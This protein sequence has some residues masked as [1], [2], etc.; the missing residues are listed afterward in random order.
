MKSAQWIAD[1]ALVTV[2]TMCL[3]GA[4]AAPETQ[5]SAAGKLGGAA[6]AVLEQGNIFN[7][8]DWDGGE[9]P[10]LYERSEQ[11]PLTAADVLRLSDNEFTDA[12]I[13]K[14]LQERR[15]ACDASVDGLLELKQ[16]GVSQAVVEAVSLHALPPNRSVDLV[17]SLDFEGLGG[18][19]AVSTEA[20][21]GYLYLIIPDGERERV[22]VGNLQAILARRWQRDTVVDNTDLLLPKK[23]RRVT[24]AAQVPLKTYGAKTAVV[25]ASTSPDIYTSADIPE[26]DRQHALEFAF[27]YP[28]SSLERRCSLQVLYRQDAMLPDRWH[29]ERSHFECEW[30]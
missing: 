1:L 4:D 17:I 20:R 27:D 8:I 22:F 28:A 15:C 9:L 2:G 23:V 13:V 19:G 16:A 6:T 11:L 3:T 29:L 25:F 7:I 12:A 10:R 30:E 24:F 5:P 14:M 18:E 21:R 26:R